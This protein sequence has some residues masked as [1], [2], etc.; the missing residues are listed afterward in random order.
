MPLLHSL[1]SVLVFTGCLPAVIHPVVGAKRPYRAFQ[2][3]RMTAS[4]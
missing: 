2:R 4:S 1:V 3:P